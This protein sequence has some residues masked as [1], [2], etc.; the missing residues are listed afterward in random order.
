[1]EVRDE[2]KEV[3]TEVDELETFPLSGLKKDK[4]FNLNSGLSQ[5][6]TIMAMTMIKEHI[7]SLAWKPANILGISLKI[8][9]HRLNV[10][11]DAKPV[12]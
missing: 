9:T 2:E 8:M 7:S 6:Q 5:N 11:P 12:K 3:R 4:V 1:M 10:C